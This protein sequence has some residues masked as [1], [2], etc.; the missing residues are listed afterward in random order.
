MIQRKTVGRCIYCRA[1]GNLTDEHV[2]PYAL[3][4]ELVLEDASCSACAKITSKDELVCAHDI[5]GPLRISYNYRT[6]RKK[7][8]P[9][10]IRGLLSV[11]GEIA[12]GLVSV[13]KMACHSIILPVLPLPGFLTGGFFQSVYVGTRYRLVQV[14]NPL[15]PLASEQMRRREVEE[16]ATTRLDETAL[17]RTL[18][19]IAHGLAVLKCGVDGFVPW[20]PQQI[21]GK[22]TEFPYVCGGCPDDMLPP[23]QG[24]DE[25]MLHYWRLAIGMVPIGKKLRPVLTACVQL[26]PSIDAPSYLIGVGSPS[27]DTYRRMSSKVLPPGPKREAIPTFLDKVVLG[28]PARIAKRPASRG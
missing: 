8:R 22:R 13:S 18:C 23:L 4:G 26:F 15:N 20:L 27:P 3:G 16:V 19:K 9:E 7:K 28:M 10:R 6:R 21:V 11:N 24:D 5:F 1:T 14:S 2:I 17:I 12:E 25:D